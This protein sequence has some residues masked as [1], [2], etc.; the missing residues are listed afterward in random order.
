MKRKDL[1]WC[2]A[3]L[4]A[5][6]MFI[7]LSI[8]QDPL[9][10]GITG[11]LCALAAVIL[12]G[13][14]LQKASHEKSESEAKTR[15]YIQKQLE[16]QV[17]IQKERFDSILNCLNEHF[18]TKQK[19][20]N[21]ALDQL[22]SYITSVT[23]GIR[24]LHDA[25][26][27]E[28]NM[29]SEAFSQLSLNLNKYCDSALSQI[30]NNYKSISDL[31]IEQHTTALKML[32]EYENN[33]IKY[34]DFIT[35]QPWNYINTIYELLESLNDEIG[36]IQN[37]IESLSSDTVACI[38][39]HTAKLENYS[40][41]YQD[42]LQSVCETL[43]QQGKESRDAMDRILKSY[44]DVTSKDIEVLTTLAKDVQL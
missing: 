25:I 23:D 24:T 43:E 26:T 19:S 36:T 18:E 15:E 16:I 32:D 9:I 20:N 1:F 44:S 27:S 30:I 33:S 17:Q 29:R 35:D 37:A 3:V 13:F 31:L 42:K 28:S 7:S 4:F 6:S 39:K 38:K 22:Q 34:Y 12:I 41:M 11:G 40:L 8:M 5:L 21:D 14:G 10:A 2:G